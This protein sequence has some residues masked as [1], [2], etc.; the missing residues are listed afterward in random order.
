MPAGSLFQPD[1]VN[2]F[3][4]R[5]FSYIQN[6]IA[7]IL[8]EQEICRIVDIGG[9][10]RYWSMG[11]NLDW[12]RVRVTLVN[13]T[14]A[15][16]NHKGIE[17]IVGDARQLDRFSD[18]A[19]DL[20]H[21]N[22]VIEHVGLW[23]DMASM[24]AEVRR[25]APRYFVQTPYYW[26]PFDPHARLPFWQWMPEPWRYRILMK[27]TCG[28]FPQQ[29]DVGAAVATVQSANLLDMQQFRYLFPDAKIA[30]ERFLGMRKSLLAI[31]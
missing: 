31:R 6:I 1:D 30:V 18:S 13:L 12:T 14:A 4:V 25:L 10:A 15:D 11:G 3:R 16:V 20:A 8:A 29:P 27:R 28:F 23:N 5:R 21:S 2:L 26:F 9:T 24:A 22:S 19:F 7:E 17:S